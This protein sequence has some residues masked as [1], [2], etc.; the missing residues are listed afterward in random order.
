MCVY[1]NY[2]DGIV[3]YRPQVVDFIIVFGMSEVANDR[4]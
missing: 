2:N 4:G 3:V 1:N